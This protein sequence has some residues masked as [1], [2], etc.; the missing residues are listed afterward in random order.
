MLKEYTGFTTA[1]YYLSTKYKFNHTIGTCWFRQEV[2]ELLRRMYGVPGRFRYLLAAGSLSWV[3]LVLPFWNSAVWI[4]HAKIEFHGIKILTLR[5]RQSGTSWL[6]HPAVCCGIF[7]RPF[8]RLTCWQRRLRPCLESIPWPSSTRRHLQTAP[9]CRLSWQSFEGW[10]PA[11]QTD[12]SVSQRRGKSVSTF[13]HLPQ[14][15]PPQE[16]WRETRIYRP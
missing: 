3:Q 10:S 5:R 8:V 13:L 6:F 4:F 2:V 15:L 11:T 1:S 16:D 9:L 7:R 12:T 14:F